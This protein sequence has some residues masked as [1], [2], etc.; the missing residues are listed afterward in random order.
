ML[1]IENRRFSLVLWAL[2]FRRYTG[3]TWFLSYIALRVLHGFFPLSAGIVLLRRHEV[4]SRTAP[5]TSRIESITSCGCSIWIA[6]PLF[7]WLTC[8]ALRNF[9]RR[10]CAVRH[11]RHVSAPPAPKSNRLSEVSRTTGTG[12]TRGELCSRPSVRAWSGASKPLDPISFFVAS[13]Y[14]AHCAGV[15]ELFRNSE[16]GSTS[17]R[18]ATSS[19]YVLANS[20]AIRPP[21]ECPTRT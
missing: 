2:P 6:W 9:A 5:T 21:Q 20:L 3:E 10:S 15:R 17:T 12:S 18:P 4:E 13:M 1:R 16:A 8:F 7:V 11:A 19:G 14:V